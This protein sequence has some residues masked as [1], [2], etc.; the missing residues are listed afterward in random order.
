MSYWSE[1]QH[2]QKGHRIHFH[3]QSVSIFIET[4]N[5]TLLFVLFQRQTVILKD[6]RCSNCHQI[7]C[8]HQTVEL[9]WV[10]LGGSINILSQEGRDFKIKQEIAK[11]DKKSEYKQEK[12]PLITNQRSTQDRDTFKINVSKHLK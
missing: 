5:F 4:V 2:P 9:Y 1:L 8:T 10:T 12:N 6:L 3:H 7:W 11:Q